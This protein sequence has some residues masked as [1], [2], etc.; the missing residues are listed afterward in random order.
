MSGLYE[1]Y[2][3]NALNIP[4]YIDIRNFVYPACADP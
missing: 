4:T 3:G 2:T 1:F